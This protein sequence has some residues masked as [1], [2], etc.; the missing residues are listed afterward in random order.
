[1]RRTRR[2]VESPSTR[3]AHSVDLEARR[4]SAIGDPPAPND[5][6]ESRQPPRQPRPNEIDVS[7][8]RL[9]PQSEFT[10][11]RTAGLIGNSLQPM[12]SPAATGRLRRQRRGERGAVPRS[13]LGTELMGAVRHRH[14]VGPAVSV[15]GRVGPDLLPQRSRLWRWGGRTERNYRTTAPNHGRRLRRSRSER[16]HRCVRPTWSDVGRSSRAV[17]SSGA[18]R[19]RGESTK[20]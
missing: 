16:R 6:T 17:G 10:P 14:P 2:G 15:T 9:C 3:R 5:N 20:S 4:Q 11:F 18:V 7:G 1:M 8:P 12:P 19:L 13:V